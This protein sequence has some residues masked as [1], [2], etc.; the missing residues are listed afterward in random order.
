MYIKSNKIINIQNI[1]YNNYK[2]STPAKIINIFYSFYIY[3]LMLPI[4]VD[5][6]PYFITIY[7]YYED[8]C[9]Y[10]FNI[11]KIA[12]CFNGNVYGGFVRDL[13][14]NDTFNDVDLHF[15][16]FTSLMMFTHSIGSAYDIKYLT[17]NIAIIKRSDDDDDGYYKNENIINFGS[18]VTCLCTDSKTQLSLKLDL[19]IK[20]HLFFSDNIR[21]YDF[22][23]NNLTLKNISSYNVS[24]PMY[25]NKHETYSQFSYDIDTI[26]KNDGLLLNHYIKQCID[27]TL[28]IYNK[29]G[30]LSMNHEY[31]EQECIEKESD[32]GKCLIK[33]IIKM[34]NKGFSLSPQKCNNHLCI[35]FDLNKILI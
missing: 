31:F 20:N 13:F 15:D 10:A 24:S 14:S 21:H 28:I 12:E 8:R 22:S 11:I 27:K 7:N 5:L 23:C 9:Y 26:G 6:F 32:Y 34:K 33:R 30:F 25:F 1:F 17:G 19:S 4:P 18:H 29:S 16:K 2:W 35:L 3:L